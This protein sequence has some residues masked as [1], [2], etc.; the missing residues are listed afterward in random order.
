MD[1]GYMDNGYMD[2][3]CTEGRNDDLGGSTVLVLVT[4]AVLAALAAIVAAVPRRDVTRAHRLMQT[5]TSRHED[6][7]QSER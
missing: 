2:N 5:L 3:A 7:A 4:P 1:N 6:E